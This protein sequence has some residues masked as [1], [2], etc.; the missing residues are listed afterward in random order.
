M[1][2]LYQPMICYKHRYP[3]T[4]Y[5]VCEWCIIARQKESNLELTTIHY[6]NEKDRMVCDYTLYDEFE[7]V[8]EKGTYLVGSGGG[9]ILEK[10]K[11]GVYPKD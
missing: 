7:N 1:M 9:V 11:I 2:D 10:Q 5:G 4:Y 3:A 8:V 6:Y